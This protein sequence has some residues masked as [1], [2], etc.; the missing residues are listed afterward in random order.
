MAKIIHLLSHNIED[1]IATD[2]DNFDHHSIRFMEKVRKFSEMVG[3][4]FEQ[5]L[6]TLTKRKQFFETHHQK[7]FKIKFFPISI[8]LPLPLEISFPLL[9]EIL[10]FGRRTS[11]VAS[12]VESGIVWHLH[13]YYLFM[14]DFIAPL[15]WLKKQKFLMHFHG[16]GP[17][18]RLKSILYTIYHYLIGL[19]ITLNLA[20]FVLALNRDEERRIIKFLR[21]KKEKVIY[22]PSAIES[23][24]LPEI[25]PRTRNFP[26]PY[27]RIVIASRIEKIKEKDVIISI[28]KKVLQKNRNSVIEIIGLREPDK[29]L[30]NFQWKNQQQVELTGWLGQQELLEKF[31]R[32]HLMLHLFRKNEGSPITLIEALSQGLPVLAFDVEG[33]RDAVINNYTGW[34]VKNFKEFEK[35]LEETV[36]NPEK[37]LKIKK[38]CQ[39]IVRKNFLAENYFPKLIKIYSKASQT[40]H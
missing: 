36:K 16:G 9:K 20:D 3:A 11:E 21:V 19:R 29:S 10:S 26:S 6:W 37:A 7:G 17:S 33:V 27:F 12:E 31:Y 8:K 5:E 23:S 1:F 38:N 34:L 14:Y 24:L 4:N 13:S 2:Y 28:L 22:F 40:N 15:L 32:A 35:K 39:E 30:L 25:E 18:Y